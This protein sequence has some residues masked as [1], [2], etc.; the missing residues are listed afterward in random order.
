MKPVLES[1]IERAHRKIAMAAGWFVDKIM[2]TSMN[3]FPDRFYANGHPRYRCRTCNRGR[4]V[5]IE[6]K[7]PGKHATAQQKLRHKQL[8]N[9]GIEVYVVDNVADANRILGITH[10]EYVSEPE[11]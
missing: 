9:A 2:R 11:L 3:S 8:R 5:L 6:W 1:T 10:G 7:K 4:V